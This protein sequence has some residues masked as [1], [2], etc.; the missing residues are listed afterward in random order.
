MRDSNF[1][2]NYYIFYLIKKM[3][4]SALDKRWDKMI[5]ELK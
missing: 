4:Q 2:S 1:K 5:E 3:I